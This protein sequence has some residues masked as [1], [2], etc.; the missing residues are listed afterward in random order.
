DGSLDD[1]IR[2][3]ADFL[4][5]YQDQALSDKYSALVERVRNAEDV[6]DGQGDL[7]DAV[8]RSY[9]KFLSYKDEYE[10]ARLYTQTGFLEKVRRDFGDKAKLTFHLA[11][12]LIS[13]KDELTKLPIKG[14]YGQWILRV[15]PLLAKL[16]FLRG[17]AFDV[18]GYSRERRLERQ[19][20][21]DYKSAIEQIA[22]TLDEHCFDTALK[23]AQLPERVRGYGHVKEKSIIQ[24]GKQLQALLDDVHHRRGQVVKIFTRAA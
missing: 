24:F 14:V 1:V 9:F 3:R 19:L 12:P 8:A 22:T 11:P 5:D 20:I 4:V 17:T 23:I 16:K 2:R 13:R 6:L 10:V 7:T 18:F 21:I 15:F